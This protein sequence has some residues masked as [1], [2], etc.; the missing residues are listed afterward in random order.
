[1]NPQI[2]KQL[3]IIDSSKQMLYS[4]LCYT[5]KLTT[6]LNRYKDRNQ[7][8]VAD[9]LCN[10]HKTEIGRHFLSVFRITSYI[11]YKSEYLKDTE[12]LFNDF[13][14]LSASHNWR[15]K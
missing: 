6:A 2:G 8:S 4:V 1:L 7:Q 9:M 5:E 10:A 11:P 12:T 3:S 13:R 14:I 15:L